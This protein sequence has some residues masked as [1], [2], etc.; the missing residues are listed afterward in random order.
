MTLSFAGINMNLVNDCAEANDPIFS[1]AIETAV[2]KAKVS[3][4]ESTNKR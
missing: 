2:L 1:I 3:V 4:I